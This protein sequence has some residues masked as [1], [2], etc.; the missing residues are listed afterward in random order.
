MCVCMLIYYV[1]PVFYRSH[2]SVDELAAERLRH[3]DQHQ[4]SITGM[5]MGV[6]SLQYAVVR[7]KGRTWRQKQ[8]TNV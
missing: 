8:D 1:N 3:I 6:G 7:E 2:Q 5:R 4:P